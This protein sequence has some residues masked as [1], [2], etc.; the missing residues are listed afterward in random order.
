[1]LKKSW[2]PCLVLLISQGATAQTM[3]G[4]SSQMQQLPAVPNLPS[5]VAP[6]EV[7]PSTPNLVHPKQGMVFV[8]QQLHVLG[9]TVYSEAELLKVANFEPSREMSLQA[10]YAMAKKITQHY[11]RN[12]FLKH[13][14]F[15]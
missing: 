6:I 5:K 14:H 10:L 1:M 3:P 9:A 2:A 7:T 4:A 13:A 8:A 11:R 12:G 15:E